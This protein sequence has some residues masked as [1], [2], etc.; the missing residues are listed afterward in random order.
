MPDYLSAISIGAIFRENSLI[1]KVK[2]AREKHQIEAAREKLVMKLTA[3]QME[4]IEQGKKL[5]L[6]DLIIINTTEKDMKVETTTKDEKGNEVPEKVSIY[7][8][9]G[10]KRLYKSNSR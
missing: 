5:I 4:A 1:N 9:E 7:K 3:L 2:K 6:E 8:E 10:R